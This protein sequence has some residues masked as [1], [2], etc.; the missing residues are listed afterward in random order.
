[1]PV[2]VSKKQYR[3][4][5]AIAHGA[6]VKGGSRGRPPKSVAEKYTSPGKD[7]PE[8]S[9]EDRGG[10]WS[11]EHHKRH[12]EKH[13]SK[14]KKHFKKAFEAFYKGEAA[15]T[16]VMDNNNRILLGKHMHGG[17]AFPGGHVEDTDLSPE[18]GALREMKEESGLVGHNPQ[19]IHEMTHNGNNTKVYL[20]ESFRGTPKSTNE[21]NDWRWYEPQDIPW[22][23]L[24]DCCVEPLELFVSQKLGKSLK[25]MISIEELKKNVIRQRGDT[26]FEV[27]HGDALRLIGNGAFR[28][29]REA[30]KGMQDESFKDIHFDTYTLSIRKHLNDVYSGRVIDGHKVVYQFTH[31]SIPELTAALMSVFEWYLPEDEKELELLDESTLSDDAIQGGISSL[32]DN[33]KRHNIGNIYQEMETIREQMRNGMA[34][35]L[36]QVEA[37]I[38]K[39]FDKLEE[40]VHEVAG[41][42]NKLTQDAGVEVDDIKIKLR[43][44]QS[45]MEELEKQPETVEAYSTSS[46]Q[47]AAKIHDEDYPYLP[48]PKIE[49][50]PNGRITI[51]FESDWTSLDKEN[52]LKDMRARVIKKAT[53][54]NDK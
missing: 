4:M 52:F 8:Q 19:K 45:K 50:M 43:E 9:G 27:T 31:K 32:M 15:A 22:N 34:V 49:V 46:P 5:M 6:H 24:R 26:V 16:I 14:D 39:L 33:Y 47:K 35:D 40:M 21:I 44:L 42:H 25:G 37:R 2:A 54:S 11:E 48:R 20:V 10:S 51:S 23:K 38:M 28:K 18:I 53:R 36:Q 1:M 7:A 13:K 17:L 29:I 3:M 30:V 12:A 41:K